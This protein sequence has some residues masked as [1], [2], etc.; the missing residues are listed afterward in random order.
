MRLYYTNERGDEVTT[1]IS[2]PN[3]FITPFLQ[4]IH[5]RP[6]KRA[7]VCISDCQLLAIS[8]EQLRQLIFQNPR[9]QEF[10]LIIFEQAI[11]RAQ[12]FHSYPTHF[13]CL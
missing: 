10:S 13:F 1:R 7:T 12:K 2:G 11:A 5:Q 4:F 3:D 6:S 8:G 9:S